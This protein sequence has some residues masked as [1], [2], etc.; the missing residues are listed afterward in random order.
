MLLY[1]LEILSSPFLSCGG[2][3][4][5]MQ[6]ALDKFRDKWKTYKHIYEKSKTAQELLIAREELLGL[7]NRSEQERER[8]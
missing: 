7:E 1:T 5:E 4:A 8:A 6:E 2:G 3:R